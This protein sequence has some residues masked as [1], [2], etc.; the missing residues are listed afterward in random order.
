VGSIPTASTNF[1]HS[2]SAPETDAVLFDFGGTLDSDGLPWKERVYRL[3][4]AE[5]IPV[6]P[7][8][9]DPLFY[10]ADDAL[11]GAL[12]ETCSFRETVAR[13]V[14]G[15]GEALELRDPTVAPRV[16]RRF[17]DDALARLAG[18][19]P[20]LG[21]LA[22]RYRLGIVSNFYGNLGRVCDDAGIR[23]FFDV[24]VDSAAV[25]W[26]KPDPRIFRQALDALGVGPAAATFVGDSLPRDMAGARGVGMR[27]I[28]LVGPTAPG[29]GPCCPG[30]RRISA[31]SELEGILL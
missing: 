21:R 29:E 27:H 12:P 3:L 28:W 25:G 22:R 10:A 31:L 4:V 19:A 20:L 14:A 15:V 13:L 30:D 26:T 18:N 23:P 9:F 2:L 8:R 1:A 5:G 11:V 16:A 7:A 24:L 17:L 6:T